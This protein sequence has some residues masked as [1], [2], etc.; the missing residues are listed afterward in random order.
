MGPNT[1]I[2]LYINGEIVVT[3]DKYRIYNIPWLYQ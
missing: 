3:E 1:Y 2:I